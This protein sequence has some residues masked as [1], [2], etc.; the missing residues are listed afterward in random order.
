MN[1]QLFLP[2]AS[3]IVAIL[4]LLWMYFGAILNIKERIVALETKMEL[5]WKPLQN[6]L[7]TAIHHPTTQSIDEKLERFDV[8]NLEELYE[9]KAEIK[10]EAKIVE[11]KSSVKALYYT[12]LLAR[13]DLRAHDKLRVICQSQNFTAKIMR[14]V[15]G[16]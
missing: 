10:T 11:D 14:M 8:L 2:V 1:W 9:L 12:L 7:T 16:R 6:F 3:L 13:I 15:L 4:S 5:F